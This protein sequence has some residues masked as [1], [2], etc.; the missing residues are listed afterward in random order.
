MTL[1]ERIRSLRKERGISQ[2]AL[3]ESLGVSRQAV[4]KWEDGSTLPS[5]SN[6]LA[7]AEFFDIPLEEL[8][9]P[10]AQENVTEKTASQKSQRKNAMRIASAILILSA[11]TLF[12]LLFFFPG[13]FNLGSLTPEILSGDSVVIGGADGPTAIFITKRSYHPERILMILLLSFSGLISS[14]TFLLTL[15]YKEKH[16]K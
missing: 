8:V 5:T 10:D 9:R 13:I 14:L 1:Q 2:E 16:Q 4:T 12:A 7:L 15:R 3:A 6:L 11:L